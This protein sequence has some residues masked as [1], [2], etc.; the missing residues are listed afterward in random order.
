M[1]DPRGF[2]FLDPSGRRAGVLRVSAICTIT[3]LLAM[4]AALVVGIFGRPDWLEVTI[5]DQT[6]A[7]VEHIVSNESSGRS[8]GTGFAA[9]HAQ[10]PMLRHAF[11]NPTRPEAWRSLAAHASQIDVLLLRSVEIDP[12]GTSGFY[13]EPES[14]TAWRGE[15][16]RRAPTARVVAVLGVSRSQLPPARILSD[17]EQ[18]RQ[19][20]AE[21]AALAAARSYAGYV[22]DQQAFLDVPPVVIG[23]FVAE[24]RSALSDV[25][26]EVY[27]HV[28]IEALEGFAGNAVR[29]AD[30]VIV[31]VHRAETDGPPASQARVDDALSSALRRIP[32]ERLVFAIGAYSRQTDAN[33][34]ITIRPVQYAWQAAHRAGV[35]IDF[36]A[37]ALNATF[38]LRHRDGTAERFWILDAVSGFNQARAA[39]GAGF[40]GI[41]LDEIGFED[42]GI[43]TA[44]DPASGERDIFEAI[45]NPEPGF[46]GLDAH[47]GAIVAFRPG[48]RG[49]REITFDERRG[50]IVDVADMRPALQVDAVTRTATAE[51]VVALTFDDG[52]DPVETPRILDILSSRN[53]KATFY[54]VGS[55]VAANPSL[56]RRIVD[57]GHDLGNHS[58]THPNL[59]NAG[60][61]RIT[62]ELNMTQRAIE[63]A[64][65]LGTILFRPP[66]AAPNL[67]FL[68]ASELL[69]DQASELGYVFG[70][71][72][73]N[74]VDFL[75]N[76]DWIVR[77]VVEDVK[78]TRD[79]VVLLH[80]SGGNRTPT[81]E[82]LPRI[83]DELQ[84]AGYE[85]VTT[86][87]L[88]SLTRE[89]LMPATLGRSNRVLEYLRG[90]AFMM[91]APVLANLPMI[92][93]I[94]AGIG[95]GRL[96]LVL[97]LS[98]PPALSGEGRARPPRDVAVIVPAYNEEAGIVATVDSLL[99]SRLRGGIRVIVV[100]D[101]STDRTSDEVQKAFEHDPRVVLIRKPNGGKSSAL[102]TGFAL[103]TEDIVV[104]IDGDTVIDADGIERLILPFEDARVGAVAGKIVVGSPRGLLAR[105]QA[106][107]YA[108]AQNVER[109]AF[110][111]LG[112]VGVVPGAFGA[113]R[114]EVVLAHGGYMTDTLAEDADLTWA[115]QLDG[116]RVASRNDALAY[117][118]APESLRDFLKQRF[119]WSFGNLQ[120]A[121]KH[122]VSRS[123]AKLMTKAIL[124]G[125]VYLFQ[126]AFSV[127]APLI[128]LLVLLIIIGLFT[129]VFDPV[130]FWLVIA[131]FG[132]FQSLDFLVAAI[133][134]RREG[135]RIDRYS[136][137]LLLLQRFCY[138]QLLYYVAL[139]ALAAAGRGSL[140][141]WGKL[142]RRGLFGKLKQTPTVIDG[143]K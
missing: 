89:E 18:R 27:F 99:A 74:S 116:W 95:I 139:K 136:F 58:F 52:P 94:V 93:I 12:N 114:R 26:G 112:A 8:V 85:F 43:W 96:L 110:A 83:I 107:E 104:A 132:L 61:E 98:R 92:A 73:V 10:Q 48:S 31:D 14:I 128:D 38:S 71:Y 68:E 64:T 122:L 82:A 29:F 53:V 60:R 137:L 11:M 124:V 47:T 50:L 42:R 97:S 79:P 46:G 119:R 101:G 87:E 57:E 33:G 84:A 123:K 28:S 121:T 44:F 70:L 125:N 51:K 5:E 22:V 24:L 55:R 117:T 49:R 7:S 113:W 138:R 103:A 80:D 35:P 45:G 34:I 135:R 62:A 133:G 56:V 32:A 4:F 39:R 41:A 76:A 9:R 72:N 17:G 120:V 30:R 1:G 141:G 75:V 126:F 127:F 143:V 66:Y 69:V 63:A 19:L 2:V 3:L 91:A 65:G 102:N 59:T 90:A 21:L 111:R 37:R 16:A 134:L 54:V 77:R 36:D 106:L 129:S 109:H 15:I 140:V 115:L 78:R 13:R 142:A 131:S 88:V 86:H 25:G 100:D 67:S 81:I 20:I 40:A 108:I 23:H 118:E 105:F 130:T 6:V